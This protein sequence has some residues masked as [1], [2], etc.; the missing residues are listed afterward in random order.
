MARA[1]GTIASG[2]QGR[3][4]G[5]GDRGDGG[6]ASAG[7]EHSARQRTN[8]MAR[9]AGGE[10]GAAEGEGRGATQ[11]TIITDSQYAIGCLTAGWK[12]VANRE[13]VEEVRPRRSPSA[14]PSGCRKCWGT[15]GRRTMS[16]RTSSPS[17]RR[18]RGRRRRAR[19]SSRVRSRRRRARGRPLS[20]SHG[21]VV[22]KS[23]DLDG[24]RAAII[25][26]RGGT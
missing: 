5:G 1:V 13:L 11:V 23:E 14:L 2:R 26:R 24:Q 17:R 16:A 10:G 22:A 3:S 4:C 12:V 25:S 18:R 7:V 15:P 8:Q 9:A 21:G 20:R 19:G 6:R